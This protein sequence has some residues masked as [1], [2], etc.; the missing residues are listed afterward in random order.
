MQGSSRLSPLQRELLDGFFAH[1]Q[2]FFL[3]G[4]AALVGYYLHH[5]RTSD[6]DLFA[7]RDV[8]IDEGVRALRA[9]AEDLGASIESLQ[10]SQDFRRFAIRRGDE[11]TVVDLVIDRAPQAFVEKHRI[12]RIRLDPPR[13]IAA[14]KLCTLLD[15][16]EV[17]D[18]VDLKLL[19]AG[20]IT[21]AEAI[22]DARKKHAGADPG[23]L[24]WLLGE[25]RIAPEHPT[26]I[27]AGISAAELEA[28]RHAL[29]DELARLALPAN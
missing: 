2:H 13:E 27:E 21:L 29:I 28:F 10:E 14:N 9:T 22:S 15:R 26:L 17:R 12:G 3:T 20:G 19:L 7:T 6:L 11:L 24:A 25:F 18:L 8:S 16:M 4:G 5:R 1:E 23:T